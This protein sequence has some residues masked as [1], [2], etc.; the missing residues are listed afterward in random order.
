MRPAIFLSRSGLFRGAIV[1][2]GDGMML[3]QK[4]GDATFYGG[5]AREVQE[6]TRESPLKIR[7]AGLART[8]SR[9]GY[10][11][12]ALVAGADLFHSFIMDQGFETA[13]ILAQFSAALPRSSPI[14]STP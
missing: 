5:L 3:V 8:I 1:C 13:R 7:L 4:V 10:I 2:S 12:A 9:L 11:A 6:E 14:S